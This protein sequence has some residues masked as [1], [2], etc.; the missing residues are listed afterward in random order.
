MEA[1]ARTD[2]LPAVPEEQLAVLRERIGWDGKRQIWL[3]LTLLP[4]TLLLVIGS[5]F[6]R[7]TP[8]GDSL[9]A[10]S[11]MSLVTFMVIYQ[12]RYNRAIH[13]LRSRVAALPPAERDAFLRQYE[14]CRVPPIREI[15]SQVSR[16][17]CTRGA[18]LV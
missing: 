2:A 9:L 12:V 7:G 1:P 6:L 8:W 11:A 10:A 16:E 18:E 4:A 5:R 15:V 13:W 14:T 17:V 3:M